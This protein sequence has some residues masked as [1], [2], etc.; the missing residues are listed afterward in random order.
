MPPKKRAA[1]SPDPQPSSNSAPAEETTGKKISD[2][3]LAVR[4]LTP[5]PSTAIMVREALKSLDSRKGVSSQAIQSYIKQNYPSVDLVRLKHLVRRALKKGIESGT[6]VRP[7][8]AIVTTGALGKFRLAPK[9]KE[10]K[11]KNENG[12]PNVQKALNAAK[13]RAKKTQTA[14]AAKKKKS[15]EKAKSAEKPKSP[16]TSGDE[17]A[18][19]SK[20][21]PARKPKAKKA[22]ATGSADR[23]SD[24]TKKTAKPKGANKEKKPPRKAAKTGS[25]APA[26]K[27]AGKRVKKT[28]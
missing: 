25:D 6:L 5:H 26:S 14:A 4:K 20:V 16:K 15:A 8:N 11:P 12:D 3:V 9:A 10:V 21:S 1:E 27:A 19:P 18:A 2:P 28:A 13:D 17:V 7:A 23:S 24:S 22:V